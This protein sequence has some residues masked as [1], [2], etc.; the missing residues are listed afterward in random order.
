VVVAQVEV[1]KRRKF[2][3]IVDEDELVCASWAVVGTLQEFNQRI[4]LGSR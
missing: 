2:T 3:R 1:S 4:Y